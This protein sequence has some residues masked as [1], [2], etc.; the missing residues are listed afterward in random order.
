MLINEHLVA[1]NLEATSKEDAIRK[2]AAL[3]YKEG[4]IN[5]QDKY[6]ESVLH[7]EAEYS[8]G[9]GF[10]VAIP[11]GRTNAVNEPVLL[12]ATVKS[13]DWQSLD[14]EPIDLIFMIGVPEE[15]TGE[16]HLRILAALSRK[17]MKAPFREALRSV[18]T[19]ADLIEVMREN[20]LLS[21]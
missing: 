1:L 7:R 8:T 12:F 10:G 3:A 2:L 13:M 21:I 6:I 11:H 16:T 4:R 17:L 19:P 5:D 20:D 18:T 14:G 9:V 15:E